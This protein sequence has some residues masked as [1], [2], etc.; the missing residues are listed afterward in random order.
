MEKGKDMR[1]C[2]GSRLTHPTLSFSNINS[3]K[4]SKRPIYTSLHAEWVHSWPQ[5][6]G[7]YHSRLIIDCP[8]TLRTKG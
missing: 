1:P 7:C 3:L 4:L 5:F 8:R 2:P 6:T